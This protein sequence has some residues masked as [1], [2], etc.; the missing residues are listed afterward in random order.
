MCATPCIA[1]ESLPQIAL[2]SEEGK[3][4]EVSSVT[5]SKT[6]EKE[7][8]TGRCSNMRNITL[9]HNLKTI[10]H[11]GK[12]KIVVKGTSSRMVEF[13]KKP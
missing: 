11:G 13:I 10:V 4:E 7:R 1:Y 12:Q 2:Q 3:S 5:L 9:R 6:L 8:G